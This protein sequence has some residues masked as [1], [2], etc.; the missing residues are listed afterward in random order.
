MFTAIIKGNSRPC[1]QRRDGSGDEHLTS[2]RQSGHA[3]PDMD[4][5][6]TEIVTP[7]LDFTCM[8]ASSNA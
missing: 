7:H 6:A 2:A 3:R 8:D 4:G 5:Q 1:H